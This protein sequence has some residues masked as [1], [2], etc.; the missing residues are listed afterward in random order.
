M[1]VLLLTKFGLQQVSG[2]T[3]AVRPSGSESR[4]RPGAASL[5]QCWM[6]RRCLPVFGD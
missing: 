4:N 3:A 1:C 5:A 6:R 2:A